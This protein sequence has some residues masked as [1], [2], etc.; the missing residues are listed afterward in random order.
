MNI[1]ITSA[2]RR[3]SLVREFQFELKRKYPD[4]KVF[5]V[6]RHPELSSACQ[7]ADK[8]FRVPSLK[9]NG[10][11]ETLLN[12]CKTNDIQCVIPTI[13]TELL[14][15]SDAKWKF[16]SEG[17]HCVVSQRKLIEI[18]R[19]KRNTHLFFK[20]FG[21]SH[22]QEYD[23]DS[24]EYP[25]F[26][27]PIDGSS[28]KDLYVANN[29][30]EIPIKVR[31]NTKYMFLE[32]L[33]PKLHDEVTV[34]LYYNVES[35]LC[36]LVPRKRI[37]VRSGEVSKAITQKSFLIGYLKDRMS[38]IEGFKGCI[39]LQ[40][41]IA[42]E[43]QEVY[44]IEINPRFGGGYPLSYAAGANYPKWII[45]EYFENKK[46][47]YFDEWEDN[48]LMLRYDDEVLIHG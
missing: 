24:I 12:L 16:E 14:L 37:E 27:K 19:E 2:G 28:S 21:I 22:A 33:D 20:K 10:Y 44:G 38:Y 47:G 41:F 25:V 26:I 39:T 18:C 6:D 9:D 46:I 36:C 17:I 3:V 35:N 43:T 23:K 4:G 48:L 40:V 5:C 13:D 29:Y 45:E 42:K 32:Y 7:I 15:L 8:S 1:L 30:Q 34:D 11:I 31:D